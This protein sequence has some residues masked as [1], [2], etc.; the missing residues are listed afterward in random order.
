MFIATFQKTD[1]PKFKADKNSNKPFIGK[2]LAGT[3]TGSIINGTMFQRDGLIENKAYLCQNETE[4][5]NGK[6]IV[7]TRVISEVSLLELQPL[8][9]QLGDANVVRDTAE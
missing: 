4:V 7:H 2:V 9:A 1:S 8:M 3:S 6:D 5:Y